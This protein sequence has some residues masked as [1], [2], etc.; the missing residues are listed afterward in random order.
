MEMTPA[1]VDYP[2]CAGPHNG[3]MWL[4]CDRL[5][6]MRC[7]PQRGPL[8]GRLCRVHE[9]HG[10]YPVI[11]DIDHLE[12]AGPV[13]LWSL[14]DVAPQVVAAHSFVRTSAGCPPRCVGT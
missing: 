3:P 1:I 5:C 9:L 11:R 14:P 10:A 12:P 8:R 6:G 4:L 2:T 7:Q 13:K